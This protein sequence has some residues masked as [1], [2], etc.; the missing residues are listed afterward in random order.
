[1]GE[2]IFCRLGRENSAM[3]TESQTQIAT[4][5]GNMS[6]IMVMNKCIHNGKCL[7]MQ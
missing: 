6:C 3:T 7:S 5:K 4:Q 2:E 1:M